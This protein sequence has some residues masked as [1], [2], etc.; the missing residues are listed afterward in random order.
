MIPL[1]LAAAF[2]LPLA[3]APR[4]L[5]PGT[6]L[7]EV[8][9]AVFTADLAPGMYSLRVAP[10]N[11]FA[12]VGVESREAGYRASAVRVNGSE[13][14]RFGITREGTYRITVSS[15]S[16]YEIE[17]VREVERDAPAAEPEDWRS[18]LPQVP[19]VPFHKVTEVRLEGPTEIPFYVPNGE[20]FEV[21]VR[22][23]EGAGR[24]TDA[25]LTGERAPAPH[26]Y[27]TDSEGFHFRVT[28]VL[29]PWYRLRVRGSGRIRISIRPFNSHWEDG[30]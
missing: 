30:P 13:P 12:R 6:P 26:W 21:D 25:A 15:P 9:E 27:R 3:P 20:P 1:R 22:A 14:F 10:R 17:L 8:G 29:E 16:S 11:G 18:S 7:V 28:E 4:T 24:L 19:L 23:V 2:L 5:P